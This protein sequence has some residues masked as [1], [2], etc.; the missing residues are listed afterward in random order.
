MLQTSAEEGDQHFRFQFSIGDA[1]ADRRRGG[2][3][4]RGRGFNSLLEMH[5]V[6][7]RHIARALRD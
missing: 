2:R 4:D 6:Y 1:G 5:D 3:A 7:T